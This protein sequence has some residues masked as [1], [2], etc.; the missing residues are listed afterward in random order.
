MNCQL[1]G[2]LTLQNRPLNANPSPALTSEL[3][4]GLAF[5]VSDPTYQTGYPEPPGLNLLQP[6]DS[7]SWTTQLPAQKPASL[8]RGG[9]PRTP[10]S[11]Q[12]DASALPSLLS[13]SVALGHC[14]C[15]TAPMPHH[16]LPSPLACPAGKQPQITSP[17]QM[18]CESVT[19]TSDIKRVW[20]SQP[21]SLY[22]SHTHGGF[23]PE[24]SELTHHKS[25]IS[26]VFGGNRFLLL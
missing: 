5:L 15:S 9:A 24:T 25:S 2:I 4:C 11:E 18:A 26:A 20:E 13:C 1:E 3:A 14:D 22:L 16:A 23:L 6:L 7:I 21:S 8:A 12:Q 17:S 19:S 10:D